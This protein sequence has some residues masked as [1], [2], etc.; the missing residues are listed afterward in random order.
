[1]HDG[2]VNGIIT[3]NNRS[4][5]CVKNQWPYTIR[6][7]YLL[8]TGKRSRRRQMSLKTSWSGRGQQVLYDPSCQFSIF[9]CCWLWTKKNHER[10]TERDIRML[11]HIRG[12]DYRDN[13]FLS[14]AA[15]CRP[16]ANRI[17][18]QT[19]KP[20]V[21]GN[22]M[23]RQSNGQAK[24]ATHRKQGS[25]QM[26][27]KTLMTF[28]MRYRYLYLI[29]FLSS[30]F[31]LYVASARTWKSLFVCFFHSEYFFYVVQN[32][33]KNA[34]GLI[35]LAA[36]IVLW[37]CSWFSS[38]EGALLDEKFSSTPSIDTKYSNQIQ[39]IYTNIQKSQR[40]EKKRNRSSQQTLIH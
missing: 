20:S 5:Y 11:C 16:K 35:L 6:F 9:F 26:A 3:T 8:M 14:A 7:E 13:F 30:G 37:P 27:Q 25:E 31:L 39:P 29:R 17:L 4:V 2:R 24:I 40:R 33:N 21:L 36:V 22:Q 34:N 18:K 10:Q 23:A 12:T 32:I 15:E 38:R 1:M 19:H 28:F